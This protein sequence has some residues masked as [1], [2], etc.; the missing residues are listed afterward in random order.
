MAIDT[1][2]S[3]TIAPPTNNGS[4]PRTIPTNAGVFITEIAADAVTQQARQVQEASPQS[5]ESGRQQQAS[6][7]PSASSTGPSG[8]TKRGHRG[9]HRWPMRH[10]WQAEEASSI[11]WLESRYNNYTLKNHSRL[12]RCAKHSPAG[13]LF[14]KFRFS[15]RTTKIPCCLSVR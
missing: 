15:R 7:E 10:Q 3:P 6:N 4:E 8:P 13:L 9:C 1:F 12:A 5:Q 11:L 2:G 14:F